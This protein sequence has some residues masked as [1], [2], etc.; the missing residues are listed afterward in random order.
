M[1]LL[2]LIILRSG[3][4]EICAGKVNWRAR[5]SKDEDEPEPYSPSCFETHRSA[6]ACGRM[7]ARSRCDAPQ[8]EGACGGEGPIT[9]RRMSAPARRATPGLPDRGARPRPKSP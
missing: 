9:L 6:A 8:H 3:G 7:V 1:R 2:V 4:C 5:F